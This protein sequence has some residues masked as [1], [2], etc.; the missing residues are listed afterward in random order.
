M[1]YCYGFLGVD[2]SPPA[3]WVGDTQKGG[4][5]IGNLE[6]GSEVLNAAYLEQTQHQQF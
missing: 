3:D 5:A 6:D 2:F 4:E 1:T